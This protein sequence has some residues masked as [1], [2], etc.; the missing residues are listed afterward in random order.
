[1]P[2]TSTAVIELQPQD[3]QDRKLAMSLRADAEAI[4]PTVMEQLD[5][6][7]PADHKLGAHSA[8]GFQGNFHV[9]ASSTYPSLGKEDFHN[10]AFQHQMPFGVGG[11]HTPRQ[12]KCGVQTCHQNYVRNGDGVFQGPHDNLL[13]ANKSAQLAMK[14]QCFKTGYT[15]RGTTSGASW[16]SSVTAQ[17]LAHAAIFREKVMQNA[18][19]RK[20]APSMPATL[21]PQAVAFFKSLQQSTAVYPYSPQYAWNARIRAYSDVYHDGKATWWLSLTPEATA[22]V[23]MHFC[24]C[25][26]VCVSA[27]VCACV[28]HHCLPI[29]SSIHVCLCVCVCVCV[30]VYV[31]WSTCSA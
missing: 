28:C 8:L 21:R 17:E 2:Q 7:S 19:S 6:Q 13:L 18:F 16:L 22:Q 15:K 25:V 10:T 24:V 5:A 29:H 20:P 27:C 26:C 3:H 30:C 12:V 11:P 14:N 1:M 23:R 31:C 4:D 9:R